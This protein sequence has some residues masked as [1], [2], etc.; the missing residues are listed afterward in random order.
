MAITQRPIAAEDHAFLLQLYASTRAEEL[1]AWGWDAA[2]QAAFLRLQFTAQQQ[3]YQ[4]NFPQR[5]QQ[6]IYWDHQAIGC[7]QVDR[8][9]DRFHLIDIALLPEYRDRGIGTSLLQRLCHEAQQAQ[10]SIQ[11]HVLQGS[12]AI[13]LYRRLGFVLIEESP[14]YYT[15]EWQP[16]FPIDREDLVRNTAMGA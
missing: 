13:R 4:M 1:Q 6:L 7:L 5:D 14:L 12:P 10:A 16:D 11:L 9:T 3:A 8:S 2:Q 15:M